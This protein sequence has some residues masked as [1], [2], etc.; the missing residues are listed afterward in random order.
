MNALPSN[1]GVIFD[2]WTPLT[3]G[4][5]YSGQGNDLR[6]SGRWLAPYSADTLNKALN[7]IDFK[8]RFAAAA[9]ATTSN[10]SPDY[11]YKQQI[12]QTLLPNLTAQRMSI[13][14]CNGYAPMSVDGSG[15]S[16]DGQWYGQSNA[17]NIIQNAYLA[18]IDLEWMLKPI[19]SFGLNCCYVKVNGSGEFNEMGTDR[20]GYVAQ[21]GPDDWPGGNGTMVN[22]QNNNSGQPFK[23][24]SKGYT[25]VEP[26]DSVEIEYPWV[27]AA[28]VNL[29]AMRALRGRLNYY[30]ILQW[31]AGTLLYEASD[32]E[33]AYSPLG[34][35]GY[36]V[37][38]HFTA[39]DIDWNLVPVLPNGTGNT[40]SNSTT[41]DNVS[42]GWATYRPPMIT[43]NVSGNVTVYPN[44]PQ[45]NRYSSWQNRVYIYQ[46]MAT[47]KRNNPA[48]AL[49]FYGFDPNASWYTPPCNPLPA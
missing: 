23:N 33:S 24:L 19:N 44:L 18:M 15:I 7:L 34:Y 42:Y 37:V 30:D 21:T 29:G 26:K 6:Y 31:K 4:F 2:G 45:D 3:E 36:K 47:N 49:F 20:T 22:T 43:A 38:H 35:P 27:D 41:W 48:S 14:P 16:T 11:L 1:P 9:T 12:E 5:G 46:Q 8:A 10:P 17:T 25:L 28:L 13:R 39:R 32:V 40:T